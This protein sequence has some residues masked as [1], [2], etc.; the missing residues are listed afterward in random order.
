MPTAF[1]THP[2]FLL[3]EMGPYHPECP[4]RLMAISDRLIASGIDHYLLAPHG[5]G[6]DA[7]A[8]RPR[9]RRRL[10][11][12]DRRG[13]SRGGTALHRPGHRAQSAFADGR[14][15]RGG[16]RRA[17]RRPRDARRVQDRVL[18]GAA[19][20]TPRRAAARDGLLPLQQRG[21]RRRARA[22]GARPRARR[23]RRLRRPSRQRHRGHLPGRRARADGVDVPASA[24]SVLRRRQSG[25][26]HGQR[27]AGGGRGQRRVP[28]GGRRALA[29]GARG[30]PA[31]D[32][33]SSR[34]ASTR[35][36]RIRWPGSS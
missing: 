26:E 15:A 4:E 31:A 27:A 34:R 21:R 13:Q 6:R 29:A 22:R 30:A 23:D 17:G 18:R 36:A 10:H 25:A 5:A 19:A 12:R 9:P 11:R 14:A 24:L 3:H 1:I 32:R 7:R 8:D 28:R 20:G 35:T 2:S 16:R 33:S